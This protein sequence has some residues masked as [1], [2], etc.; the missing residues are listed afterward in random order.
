MTM[1][2]IINDE[3]MIHMIWMLLDICLCL[4]FM[5]LVMRNMIFG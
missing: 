2:L 4:E 5:K 3:F 1:L